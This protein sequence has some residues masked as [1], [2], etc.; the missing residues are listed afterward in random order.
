MTSKQSF[1]E[2]IADHAIR[3]ESLDPRAPLDDL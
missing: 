2:W 1:T 3:T